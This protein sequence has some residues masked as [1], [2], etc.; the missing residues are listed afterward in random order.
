MNLKQ[1]A[2]AILVVV[3]TAAC[4]F[5][6]ETVADNTVRI[7]VGYSYGSGAYIGD[8][9]VLTCYHVFRDEPTMQSEVWFKDEN[10]ILVS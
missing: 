9:L 1:I 2:I 3:A 7:K 4:A 8:R 5:S 6:Q 10:V